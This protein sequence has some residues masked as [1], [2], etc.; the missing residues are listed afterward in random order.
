[1]FLG[2]CEKRLQILNELANTSV[3]VKGDITQEV[4]LPPPPHGKEEQETR[5]HA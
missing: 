1:V 2:K 4:E 3:G 5:P